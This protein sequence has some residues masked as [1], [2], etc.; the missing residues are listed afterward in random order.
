MQG[1]NCTIAA[2]LDA[3]L[4]ARLSQTV[5]AGFG[6]RALR[7]I[8]GLT[9]CDPERL[10]KPGARMTRMIRAKLDAQPP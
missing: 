5:C 8:R 3:K 2:R 1:A 6:A 7:M 4:K 9:P 10:A